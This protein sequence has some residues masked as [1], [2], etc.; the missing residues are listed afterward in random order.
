MQSII[1]QRFRKHGSAETEK[2]AVEERCFR[3][4]P[5]LSVILKTINLTSADHDP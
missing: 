5:R 4:G 2:R 3:C 1:K